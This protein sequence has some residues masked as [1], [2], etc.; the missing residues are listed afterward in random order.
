L[1]KVEK[2]TYWLKKKRKGGRMKQKKDFQGLEDC[3]QGENNLKGGGREKLSSRDNSCL[4]RK[5]REEKMQGNLKTRLFRG[6][7]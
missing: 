3:Y 7:S 5:E 2:R 1:E 4:K 6:E